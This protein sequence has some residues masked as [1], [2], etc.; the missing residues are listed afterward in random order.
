MRQSRN[1]FTP[2]SE[3]AAR[4]A[5]EKAHSFRNALVLGLALVLF[6]GCISYRRYLVPEI[7][8][9]SPPVAGTPRGHL[10]YQ[11]LRA[12]Q[13]LSDGMLVGSSGAPVPIQ[14]NGESLR[15]ARALDESGYFHSFAAAPRGGDLHLKAELVISVPEYDSWNDLNTFSFRLFPLWRPEFYDLRV[16]ARWGEG[17]SRSYRLHDE[18]VVLHWTPLILVAPFFGFRESARRVETNLYRTVIQMMV[19]DG[20][21]PLSSPGER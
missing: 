21:L 11:L 12:Y 17:E 10:T 6:T 3:P 14:E 13:V 4:L 9:P 20:V 19:E 16:K 5:P 7:G 1:G 8:A 2:T 18:L 15:L